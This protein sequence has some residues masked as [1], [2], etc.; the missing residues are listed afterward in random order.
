MVRSFGLTPAGT[1]AGLYVIVS[2]T[3]G[4]KLVPLGPKSQAS[5]I[6][7]LG[8]GGRVARFSC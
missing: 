4:E 6:A 7:V 8:A 2:V 1:V 5:T 3:S